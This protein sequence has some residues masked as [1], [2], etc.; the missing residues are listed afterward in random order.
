MKDPRLCYTLPW[1][2]TR[3]PE[4][5]VIWVLREEQEIV[6]S[7]LRRQEQKGEAFSTLTQKTALELV[8]KYN[9]AATANIKNSGAEV[10]MIKYKDLVSTDIDLQ[11]KSWFSL[12][13]F[14]KV[15]PGA[16]EG[17]AS[18]SKINRKTNRIFTF[19]IYQPDGPLVSVIVPN[20]N[21][22]AIS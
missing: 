12:Y 10:C 18:S 17:F 8:Y 6:D 16:M 3:F 5:K 4:A 11:R 1:W 14:C 2:L 19:K 22:A 21:H 13:Q 7:L 20:Y 15:R 9:E